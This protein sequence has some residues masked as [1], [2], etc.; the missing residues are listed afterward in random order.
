MNMITRIALRCAVALAL[1]LT[2]LVGT[3]LLLAPPVCA[4]VPSH[5]QATVRYVSSVTGSD[6]GNDCASPS[7][8]CATLQRAVDQASAGDEV[9]IATLDN[10]TAARYTG[11]SDTV[12]AVS[13]SLTL[14]GGYVYVHPIPTM[15]LPGVVP[16]TV[17]GERARRPLTVS[18]EVTVTLQLLSFVNGYA[19]QGGNVYAE[20]AT[21]SFIATPILNGSATAGGGLYLRNCRSSFDPGGWSGGIPGLD[22]LLL[23]QSNRA[24]DGGGVYVEGGAPLLAGLAI[25]SNT[26]TADGGGLY[27]QG[28]QPVIAGVVVL[29]NHADGL[30]GG[31]FLSDSAARIATAGI[32]SNTAAQGGGLYVDG[33]LTVNP[34]EMPIVANSYLCH[35]HAGL[36][37]AVYLRESVTGLVNNIIADNE[38]SN[39][40]GLYLWGSS[41]LLAYNTVAQNPGGSS[42]HLT[43][44]PAQ[45]WPPLLPL[46][47]LPFFANTIVVSHTVGIY[48]ETTHLPYPFENRATLEGTLWWGNGQDHTG[49]GQVV[50][51]TDVS[52]DPRFTCTGELPD[53]LDPYHILTESPAVD[54]GITVT[55]P[56]PEGDLFVDIDGQLRPSGHG[57]DIGADEAMVG[58]YGVW[59]APPVALGTVGPG[60]TV[61]YT[62]RLMNVGVETDT[63][64]LEWASSQGWAALLTATPITLSAQTSATVQ[65]RVSVPPE[66]NAGMTD[67]T[68]LTALSRADS[69]VRAYALDLTTVIGAVPQADL[70][71][72]KRADAEQVRPGEPLRYT[73]VVTRAGSLTA[74]LPVTLTDTAV[75]AHACAGWT[76][77]D[78]CAGDLAQGRFTCTLTLLDGPSP[79]TQTLTL[80]ITT[81]RVYSGLLVNQA[82]VR[83]AEMDPNPVDN[84]SLAV[85]GVV[86]WPERL[87]LPVLLRGGGG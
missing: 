71:I 30:G 74:A 59:L 21:V 29:E 22:G 44:R 17:D 20:D 14:R 26:A 8:P 33:P 4:T 43:H 41:P 46:P 54:T 69:N 7:T 79:V 73:L 76:L 62:H 28:G 82:T 81:S 52:G 27:L 77:P 55:L 85:V 15:W 32:Y 61:T 64:D 13:K 9:R 25:Y 19:A 57:Y 65:V 63:Y 16:A 39:G 36:G 70:A 1:G 42:I 3:L 49:P 47:S 35:N 78:G 5:V 56:L 40:A 58:S 72:D 37:G 2:A 34:D 6:A 75:P 11:S 86:A 38:A 18:G 23:V 60:E 66:A 68:T 50:H 67:T 10:L 83:S 51:S 53:C 24:A 45:V 48:V 31:L 84:T 80:I 12:V 87:Y